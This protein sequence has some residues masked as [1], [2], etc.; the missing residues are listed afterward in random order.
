[1]SRKWFF[2]S[3]LSSRRLPP[4]SSFCVSSSPFPELKMFI[5]RLGPYGSNSPCSSDSLSVT[6]CHRHPPFTR[7]ER[8][9]VE[10]IWI[11][12]G[13]GVIDLF[14]QSHLILS[15]HLFGNK[16]IDMSNTLT[17][18]TESLRSKYLCPYFDNKTYRSPLS[19]LKRRRERS[20]LL[21]L[22]TCD[23]RLGHSV[24]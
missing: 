7:E 11:L 15:I 9:N 16:T 3:P 1:M 19:P 17:I 4:S 24:L 5:T 10:W 21:L 8:L 22:M 12:E 13:K 18:M 6:K 20:D 14:N 2:L 23:S